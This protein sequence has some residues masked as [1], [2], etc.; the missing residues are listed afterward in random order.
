MLDFVKT[1]SAP[2]HVPVPRATA[3][4]PSSTPALVPRVKVARAQSFPVPAPR[5]AVNYVL[6]GYALVFVFLLVRLIP[7]NS[8]VGM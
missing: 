6:D 3:V 2:Q 8:L 7:P 5:V 4:Q 1:Y